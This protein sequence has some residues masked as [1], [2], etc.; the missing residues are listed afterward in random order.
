MDN[1][2]AK[3]LAILALFAGGGWAAYRF[4]YLPMK[5]QEDLQRRAALL[6]A[7]QRISQSDALAQLGGAGC[8]AAAAAYGIPPAASSGLCSQAGKVFAAVSRDI[9]SFV[10]KV[11]DYTPVGVVVNS[12]NKVSSV[13]GKIV[14]GVS[15]V[16][17]RLN[18]F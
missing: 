15:S 16:F 12:L 18:P 4:W 17:N 7:Q 13:P 8:I 1:D 14:S 3:K 11:S 6:A 10:N 5:F 9:P 2:A